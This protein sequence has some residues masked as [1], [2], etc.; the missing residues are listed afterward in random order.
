MMPF[1][2]LYIGG[3]IK[4]AILIESPEVLETIFFTYR[5]LLHNPIYLEDLKK[6]VHETLAKIDSYTAT[7]T[8]TTDDTTNLPMPWIIFHCEFSQKRGPRAFRHLRA[9]DR[10]LNQ[11]NWPNLYFPEIYMLDG[12]YSN[13]YPQFPVRYFSIQISNF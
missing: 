10:E 9:K 13:F 5:E 6:N 7:S 4:G 11:R 3:H 2:L 1:Y 12:G 8:L